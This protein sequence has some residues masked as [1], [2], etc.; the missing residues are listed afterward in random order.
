MCEGVPKL[1]ISS[2]SVASRRYW[3]RFALLMIQ[4][5][6]QFASLKSFKMIALVKNMFF[7]D[8]DDNAGCNMQQF[9]LSSPSRCLHYAAVQRKFTLPLFPVWH[10]GLCILKVR[11][12]IED[13]E[14]YYFYAIYDHFG[15]VPASPYSRLKND[16][17][18]IKR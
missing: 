8:T 7:K 15:P 10:L 13:T 2:K 4:Y 1:V 3:T 5:S 11:E 17:N 18:A 12:Y 9:N 14:S 6:R 16:S